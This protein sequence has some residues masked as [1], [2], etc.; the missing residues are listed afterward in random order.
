MQML[1]RALERTNGRTVGNESI[2]ITQDEESPVRR[3]PQ[4]VD[5]QHL[6]SKHSARISRML[7]LHFP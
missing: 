2:G 5:Q 6:S 7:I 3:F 4:E 1:A